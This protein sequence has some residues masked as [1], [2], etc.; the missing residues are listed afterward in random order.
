M[1]GYAPVVDMI[2]RNMKGAAVYTGLRSR[3]RHGLNGIRL[4]WPHCRAVVRLPDCMVPLAIGLVALLLALAACR[5]V[6]GTATY[7]RDTRTIT[8]ESGERFTIKL[9]AS[10]GIGDDWRIVGGLERA[11]VKLVDE[12]YEADDR[13]VPGGSG[14]ASF[15]F[16][17]TQLGA[18]E[19]T[20]FN[21]YR[22]AGA[23]Q[24]SPENAQLAET[25]VFT[26]TVS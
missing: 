2:G 16:E 25:L 19:L 5:T 13:G 14:T 11:R 17:A 7:T 15:L 22:C 12:S 21:C 23:D 9:N 18:T 4:G 6:S 10:P 24:P 3:I 26:I 1:K 8:V 20:F